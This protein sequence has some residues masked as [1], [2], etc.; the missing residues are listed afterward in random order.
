MCDRPS[1]LATWERQLSNRLMLQ[2]ETAL[3][4]IY[5]YYGTFVYGLAVRLTRDTHAAE[6]V[7]QDVFTRLW[8]HAGGY[9]PERGALRAWLGILTHSAS[10]RWVRTEVA[11]RR[12]VLRQSC[13][14]KTVEASVEEMVLA[15][16][17]AQRV[18]EALDSLPPKQRR[19][20]EL[21]YFDAL[22][23]REVAETVGI[24]EGT[25][26]SRMRLALERLARCLDAEVTQSDG[27]R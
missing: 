19:A 7:M 1:A 25:A 16:V 27:P 15:D 8:D 21:A 20:V 9:D 12:R 10:V 17:M 13:A 14:A 11:E 4:E 23:Y 2:D 22:T 26:K 5:D 18:R 24:P 6:D 3:A